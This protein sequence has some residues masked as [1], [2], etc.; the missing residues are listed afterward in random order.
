[1]SPTLCKQPG[2]GAILSLHL[3]A[4]H[5]H[6]LRDA[7][8]D[9]LSRSARSHDRINLIFGARAAVVLARLPVRTISLTAATCS[10]VHA[11]LPSA[12]AHFKPDA[13]ATGL[14]TRSTNPASTTIPENKKLF[15]IFG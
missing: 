1:V 4:G 7:E 13:C 14:T 15:F 2:A 6:G 10:A 3:R 11:L 12:P 9:V 8:R 5:I